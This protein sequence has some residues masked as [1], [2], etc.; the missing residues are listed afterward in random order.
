MI[1]NKYTGS[2]LE[3]KVQERLIKTPDLWCWYNEPNTFV[4][5]F[6]IQAAFWFLNMAPNMELAFAGYATFVQLIQITAVATCFIYWKILKEGISLFPNSLPDSFL[7]GKA[8]RSSCQN[9]REEF[10]QWRCPPWVSVCMPVF[11]R[12]FSFH[13]HRPIAKNAAPSNCKTKQILM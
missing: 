12:T 1:I 13:A 10:K 11:I 2:Q 7:E 5:R 9:A 3:W 4:C 6:K 8:L